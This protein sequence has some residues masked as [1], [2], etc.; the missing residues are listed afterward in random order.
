MDAA[1]EL[2]C[3]R[4]VDQPMPVQP[5]LPSKCLRHNMYT[6]MGLASRPVSRMPFMQ[7]RLIEHLETFRAKSIRQFTRDQFIHGNADLR[8][9]SFT[10]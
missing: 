8:R 9:H 4:R 3:Q 5:A 7:M 10:V 2:G 6:E 1:R